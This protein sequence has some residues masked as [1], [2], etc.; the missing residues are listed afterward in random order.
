MSETIKPP[1]KVG[2]IHSLMVEKIGQSGDPI[3][4]YKKFII[5]LKNSK[6][7]KLNETIKIKITKVMLNFAFAERV[8]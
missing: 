6:G 8:S 5:F 7:F 2:D 3:M 4:I 1:V